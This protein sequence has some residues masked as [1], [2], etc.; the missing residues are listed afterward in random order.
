MQLIDDGGGGGEVHG[1][2]KRGRYL[3]G[4]K[5]PGIANLSKNCVVRNGARGG[6]NDGGWRTGDVCPYP[7]FDNGAGGGGGCCV[8]C[9]VESGPKSGGSREGD[10]DKSNQGVAGGDGEGQGL[11]G[12]GGH[13]VDLERLSD[14]RSGGAESVGAGEV[15]VV[16]IRIGGP[17]VDSDVG[18]V[19][20]GSGGGKASDGGKG[21]LAG[22]ARRTGDHLDDT[23]SADDRISRGADDVADLGG[24]SRPA[25]GGPSGAIKPAGG[26]TGARSISR[27]EVAGGGV[28]GRRNGRREQDERMPGRRPSGGRPDVLWGVRGA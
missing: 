24:E 25:G 21:R 13:V 2:G 17:P 7:S 22:Q 27:V 4:G 20:I 19:V 12:A 8:F 23:G 28:E 16:G 1:T 9:S 14:I 5:P 11:R 15:G 6:D 18:A 3:S 26:K 10:I